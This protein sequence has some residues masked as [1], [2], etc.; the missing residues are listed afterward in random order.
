M[1]RRDFHAGLVRFDRD[2]RLVDLDRVA[3]LDHQFDDFDFLEV[4]DVRH[5][6]VDR[7]TRRRRGGSGWR[8][9]RLLG[10]FFSGGR[11]GCGSSSRRIGGAAGF[12]E[13]QH[14]RTHGDLVADIDLDLFDDA[15]MARWN[16]HARL[17]RFDGQQRLVDL[18]RIARLDH[19]FDDFD[20][21]E[22]ADIGDF[23][24]HNAHSVSSVIVRLPCNR[25]SPGTAA[26]SITGS[27]D[28][29]CSGRCRTWRS[30]ATRWRG[31]S[32]L[33]RPASAGQQP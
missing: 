7:A 20:F 25:R 21:L 29:A 22:V 28:S 5:G 23:D 16:L 33:R 8:F 30:P 4:A 19:Q 10:R 14:Q 31:R 17:V 12:L 6:H 24:F 32:C 1:A 18:D 27:P 11:R 3:D 2:Q 26:A 15:G 9:G 13:Q